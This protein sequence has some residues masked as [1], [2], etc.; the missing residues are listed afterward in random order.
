MHL[1]QLGNLIEQLARL[2][3]IRDPRRRTRQSRLEVVCSSTQELVSYM[4]R[5]A[6]FNPP[7]DSLAG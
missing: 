4:Q 6:P 1:V 2:L 7:K 3:R 5:F